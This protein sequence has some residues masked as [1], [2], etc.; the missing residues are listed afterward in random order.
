[1]KIAADSI[2]NAEEHEYTRIRIFYTYQLF[3]LVYLPVRLFCMPTN[4]NILYLQI[5]IL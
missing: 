5:K 1:M 4:K 2:L 3:I